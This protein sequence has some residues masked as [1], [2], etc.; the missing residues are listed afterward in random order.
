MILKDFETSKTVFH[1]HHCLLRIAFDENSVLRTH[2]PTM[3]GTSE[4]DPIG[5]QLA[6]GTSFCF[7]KQTAVFALS[8]HLVKC[9][10]SGRSVRRTIGRLFVFLVCGYSRSFTF[11]SLW[12]SWFKSSQW[13]AWMNCLTE[14][15]ELGIKQE[16]FSRKENVRWGGRRIVA[17]N[18]HW[19]LNGLAVMVQPL[20][21]NHY[22]C[23]YKH[24]KV[25]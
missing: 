14:L 23:P 9:T 1:V 11:G 10:Q 13:I 24:S 16:T 5:I 20:W 12:L 2:K 4:S 15:S 22:G 19:V 7:M 17:S 18:T 25:F 3:A 21:L 6:F 8:P